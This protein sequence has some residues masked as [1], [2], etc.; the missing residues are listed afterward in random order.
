M[1]EE[2][3]RQRHGTCVARKERRLLLRSDE[4]SVAGVWGPAGPLERQGK[5]LVPGTFQLLPRSVDWSYFPEAEGFFRCLLDSSSLARLPPGTFS[6]W[7]SLLHA[8]S[9]RSTRVGDL[10]L[11][12]RAP[13][14]RSQRQQTAG[15]V[16]D[17]GR[18]SSAV[19]ARGLC[20]QDVRWA[21]VLLR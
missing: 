3:F 19:L 1:G 15:R 18:L 9:S 10:L 14:I 6:S 11:Q 17:P 21:P 2:Y 8:P 12:N 20:C 16:W 7:E 5:G 13:K 4:F